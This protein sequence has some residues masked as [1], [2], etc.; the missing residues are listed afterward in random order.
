MDIFS[1]QK[2]KGKTLRLYSCANQVLFTKSRENP[3]VLCFNDN[4][5]RKV[6]AA[7]PLSLNKVLTGNLPNPCQVRKIT[8]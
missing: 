5:I 3:R 4:S 1:K 8:N 7:A 2:F 6:R